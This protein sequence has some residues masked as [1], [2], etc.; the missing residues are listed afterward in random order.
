MGEQDSHSSPSV[1]SFE[2][3]SSSSVLPYPSR[4]VTR[5]AL[6]VVAVAS[7][8]TASCTC[9]LQ[10][11]AGGAWID[12]TVGAIPEEALLGVEVCLAG[13]CSETSLI[14]EGTKVL[15]TRVTGS[16]PV[17]ISS[18]RT[19]EGEL[20]IALS[21]EEDFVAPFEDEAVPVVVNVADLR[22]SSRTIATL[23]GDLLVVRQPEDCGDGCPAGRLE[24]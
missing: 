22:D 19:P 12:A 24:L 13:S 16:L 5:A 18:R 17:S 14:V 4:M 21:F 8:Q 2:S 23:A 1:L 10:G 11:C 9:D 7:L 15:I 6:A 20:R 3:R